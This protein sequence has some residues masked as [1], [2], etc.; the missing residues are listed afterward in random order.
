MTKNSVGTFLCK[1]LFYTKKYVDSKV[2]FPIY[3]RSTSTQCSIPTYTSQWF[4]PS[5]ILVIRKKS[6]DGRRR[7]PK[8]HIARQL[9]YR[10]V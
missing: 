5:L 1:Y 6:Y 8:E 2:R 7:N 10:L 3:I 4:K 9:V